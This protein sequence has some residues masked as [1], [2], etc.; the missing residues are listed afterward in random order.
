[1]LLTQRNRDINNKCFVLR[2]FTK[3][4]T[5][6]WL[7][8]RKYCN[9]LP[10]LGMQWCQVTWTLRTWAL[11]T[12]W[13]WFLLLCQKT[14]KYYFIMGENLFSFCILIMS[15]LSLLFKQVMIRVLTTLG[16]EGLKHYCKYLI[17]KPLSNNP[18]Q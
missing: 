8:G 15:K 17:G 10:I 11:A 3:N 16:L 1:M 4:N 18:W 5:C 6:I 9:N 7:Y 14:Q 13:K 2:N 12:T